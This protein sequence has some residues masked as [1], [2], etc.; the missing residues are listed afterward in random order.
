MNNQ[1]NSHDK[2]N[3]N[4]ID[5]IKSIKCTGCGSKAVE[6]HHSIFSIEPEYRELD[7]YICDY[8]KQAYLVEDL[9]NGESISFALS[10]GILY[11][12]NQVPF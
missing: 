7:I 6:H 1:S 9:K 5:V 10:P 3:S 12:P 11:D 8:C 2:T 4:S